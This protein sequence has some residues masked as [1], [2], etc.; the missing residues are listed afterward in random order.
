ME[1]KEKL[2][3]YAGIERLFKNG[4][5]GLLISLGG[6]GTL[7]PNVLQAV[8]EWS[9]FGSFPALQLFSIV[10]FVG[11]ALIVTSYWL[12]RGYRSFLF[13]K[14]EVLG[15]PMSELP[16]KA[17]NELRN[18]TNPGM[19]FRFTVG[20]AKVGPI[21]IFMLDEYYYT[22]NPGLVF[23][24]LILYPVLVCAETVYVTMSSQ[25][26]WNKTLA[27]YPFNAVD[28]RRAEEQK[29]RVMTLIAKMSLFIF[30]LDFFAGFG[31]VT[32]V[33]P[34]IAYNDDFYF[35][36]QVIYGA[37]AGML[38]LMLIV[39]LATKT[40][41]I[42]SV[43][44]FSAAI[45]VSII[46]WAAPGV[47]LTNIELFFI[48]S[49]L[50]LAGLVVLWTFCPKSND[51]DA[52]A[53][54]LRSSILLAVSG[55]LFWYFIRPAFERL[56]AN[57][58]NNR[59]EG[60]K[61][62]STNKLSPLIVFDER[63]FDD[64]LKRD[65]KVFMEDIIKVNPEW[66]ER[67]QLR[68][69]RVTN[70]KLK[71]GFDLK[72]FDNLV[73][74]M[75]LR[76]SFFPG[77]DKLIK[78]DTSEG[79]KKTKEAF[80]NQD[81]LNG[82]YGQTYRAVQD[83]FFK[84]FEPALVYM[85]ENDDHYVSKLEY[86]SHP[87]NFYAYN[88]SYYADQRR[89]AARALHLV[90]EIND[91]SD[92]GTLMEPKKPDKKGKV[93]AHFANA[94]ISKRFLEKKIK[95]IRDSLYN[96]Y[97]KHNFELSSLKN[98]ENDLRDSADFRRLYSFHKL[99]SNYMNEVYLE[100]FSSAQIIYRSFLGDTQRNGVFIFLAII[101]S[102][103]LADYHNRKGWSRIMPADPE[104]S[105]APNDTLAIMGI[106]VFILLIPLIRPIKPANI[107]PEHPYWM[108][109]LQHWYV[110]SFA[111]ETVEQGPINKP[112]DYSGDRNSSDIEKLRQEIRMLTDK[113]VP[114]PP[115][116]D[117]PVRTN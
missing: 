63:V 108:M 52:T 53:V 104:T 44:F 39:N 1:Q 8:G 90:T 86:Y 70:P 115:G 21:L 10:F 13:E 83:G 66:S 85:N 4:G 45:L 89:K 31:L 109:N 94:D 6:F 75:S 64:T 32:F 68:E 71:S 92:I 34:W 74:K 3:H 107:D 26:L 67:T 49:E 116:G 57:Y 46:V 73:D 84:R 62:I 112:K 29:S 41:R 60:V 58:F 40:V 14:L 54:L 76:R 87:I 95:L 48:P 98:W 12:L 69:H 106:V 96:E 28:S 30:S 43:D 17:R 110:P 47:N 82:F 7:L 20:A 36:T 91:L 101:I 111:R 16:G 102:A 33:K 78:M 59:L 25:V 97:Y 93:A 5:I 72:E 2:H 65:L 27:S 24:P 56:N 55:F 103:G 113:N 81:K 9:D 51:S 22:V 100:H 99:H 79:Q 117:P 88:F 42:D 80:S 11:P 18:G 114:S 61:V 105:S 35:T 19:L 77:Y 23:L 37:I 15:Y 38:W 50:L